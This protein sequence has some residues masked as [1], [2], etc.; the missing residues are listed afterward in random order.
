MPKTRPPGLFDDIIRQEDIGYTHPVFLQC[1]LP[2]RHSPRNKQRWQTDCGR[3]SLVI[4]A[5]EL[6]KPGEAHT[7]KTCMVP[8]GPKARFV[9][10][11]INDFI[12]REKTPTVDLGR[13]LRKAMD[14]LKIPIG[15]KNGEALQL[16]VENFAAADISLGVWDNDGSAHQLR[17]FVAETMSFWI[18]KNPEQIT[19]WQPEMTVSKGY[20]EAVR[21]GDRMAP[22]YWPAMIALKDD[23]RAMDIHCFLVYRLRKGLTRDVPLHA[24]QLH[25]LF[26]KDVQQLDHFWPRFLKSLAAALEWYPQARVEVKNDCIV[27]K[28]SPAL[29][30]YRK[31]PCIE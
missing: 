12:Q 26:G 5:G 30:P 9:V 18:E 11:Y 21:D 7:Y 27:L 25:A 17:A 13:S 8:A 4:R 10:A 16:E 3:A 22:F 23:T 1:F 19:I 2:T 28:N 15:G 14:N 29:I 24:R 20:Y 6:V 31:I